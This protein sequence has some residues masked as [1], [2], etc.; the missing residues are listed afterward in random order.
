MGALGG[1]SQVPQQHSIRLKY[2]PRRVGR[3]D[4]GGLGNVL[5]Y[6]LKNVHTKSS[7]NGTGIVVD[8]KVRCGIVVIDLRAII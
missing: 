1:L 3:R 8:P 2:A 5:S 7:S 6:R 4:G